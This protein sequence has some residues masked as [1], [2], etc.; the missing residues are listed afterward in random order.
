MPGGPPGEFRRPRRWSAA[1]IP[2]R[3]FGSAP[4]AGYPGSSGIGRQAA[5]RDG[6]EARGAAVGPAQG[7]EAKPPERCPRRDRPDRS[8]PRSSPPPRPWQAPHHAG[9]HVRCSTEVG[10]GP[11]CP[12][13]P[14]SGSSPT[15][16]PSATSLSKANRRGSL[17]PW[18]PCPRPRPSAS[19][20]DQ[21]QPGGCSR[22]A[23]ARRRHESLGDRPKSQR[24]RAILSTPGPGSRACIPQPRARERGRLL[25][26]R[27]PRSIPTRPDDPEASESPR[28]VVA[29]G[30]IEAS[31]RGPVAS[32]ADR[33]GRSATAVT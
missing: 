31:A 20:G 3:E 21:A 25:R 23:S 32:R 2:R 5:A 18:T 28:D 10:R 7:G 13:P 19:M 16:S 11:S 27:P 6:S 33:P 9:G 14:S 12:R 4:P 17:R 8:T 15:S 26:G 30:P 24:P 22:R 1:R 29:T